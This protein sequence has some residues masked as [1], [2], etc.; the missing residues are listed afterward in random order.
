MGWIAP[1]RVKM[2]LVTAAMLYS[3]RRAWHKASIRAV[4]PDPTGLIEVVSHVRD[5]CQSDKLPSGGVKQSKCIDRNLPQLI[6]QDKKRTHPPIPTVKARSFQSRPSI[7]GISRLTYE[8]GPSRISWEWPWPLK[9]SS[10][11]WPMP[12]SWE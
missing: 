3:S 5:R 8:P 7:S 4:L 11:E 9:G 2:S 6:S 10:C 12:P 1:Y